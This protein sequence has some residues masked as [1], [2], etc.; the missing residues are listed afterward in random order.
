LDPT[1]STALEYKIKALMMLDKVD[2]AESVIADLE[3]LEP[4]L[5]SEIKE[6]Y[7]S[8]DWRDRLRNTRAYSRYQTGP[9]RP[10]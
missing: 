4:D 10:I 5:A 7:K 2:D 3:K 8:P 9:G 1:D 6:F